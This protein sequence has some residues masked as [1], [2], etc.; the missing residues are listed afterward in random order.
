MIVLVAG[1]EQ[2][3][4]RG[5]NHF[6]GGFLKKSRFCLSPLFGI[7]LAGS[8]L[9][10]VPSTSLK[11]L[12]HFALEHSPVLDT[13]KRNKSV[14]ELEIQSAIGKFKPNLDLTSTLGLQNNVPI[15]TQDAGAS[16]LTNNP[17]AP[18]Y[19]SL[20]LGLT[21]TLYDNGV[22]LNQL[23]VAHL[24]QRLAE[25]QWRKARASL[26]LDVATEYYHFSLASVL[27]QVRKKQQEV[28]DKQFETLKGQYY[29]G[30]K[31][32]SDFL[33]LKT[34][35]QRAELDRISSENDIV[36]SQTNLRKLIGVQIAGT[37]RPVLFDPEN[38]EQEPLPVTSFPKE[39]PKVQ[40][41][42]DSKIAEIQE[43]ING[44]T[45]DL[46]RRQFL[47]RLNLAAGM[48]YSNQNFVNGQS[49]FM[50]GNQLSWNVL[51]TIQ[52]N[53][54]DWGTRRRD[55]DVAVH[56]EE[57]QRNSLRQNL[58]EV[59]SQ[60]QAVMAELARGQR[61]LKLSRELLEMETESNQ[62][63]EAQYRE[64]K[65]SYL[66]LVTSLDNFLNAKISLYSS[67]FGALQSL[68]K[69]YYYEGTLYERLMGTSD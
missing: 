35:V 3:F 27:L 64:G 33:R 67:H 4:N 53:L 12:L 46:V 10:Q 25:I 28:L 62:T 37:D 7:L 8:A 55:I 24:N 42:Y 45:V 61:S 66:D 15:A 40:S 60:I 9:A 58:L 13:A 36:L 23:D 21:E 18:W 16:L 2:W 69:Y 52:Y 17:S 68:V 51:A 32:K 14:R 29:Q 47:P 49:D 54:W 65:V 63:L 20:S 41:F 56:N 44:Q 57:I 22:S 26:V 6:L 34:Q 48:T 59:N 50:A 31:T 30:F 5:R 43:E 39:A 1:Q 11:E 19:S 38:L